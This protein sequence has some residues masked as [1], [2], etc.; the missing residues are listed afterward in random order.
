ML[1]Y[2]TYRFVGKETSSWFRQKVKET[3]FI[4]VK[5][6]KELSLY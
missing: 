3:K 2:E 1:I 5:Q 4:D 6:S